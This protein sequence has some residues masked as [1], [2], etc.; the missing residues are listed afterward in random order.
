VRRRIRLR[1][2]VAVAVGT[3]AIAQAALATPGR[4]ITDVVNFVEA[5]NAATVRAKDGPIKLELK[6]PTDVLVQTATF[7]PGASSGWHAH[8]GFVILAVKSGTLTRYDEHCR[9]QSFAAGQAFVEHGRD[10]SVLVTNN[11]S[12]PAVTVITYVVPQGE[13]PMRRIDTPNPGCLIQ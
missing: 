4:G 10:H 12:E 13:L 1:T 3:L 6:A 9:A 7:Q 11:R 5:T 2:T 8:P